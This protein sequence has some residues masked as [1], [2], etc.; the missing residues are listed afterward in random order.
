MKYVRIIE[1][2]NYRSSNYGRL[3]CI[4]IYSRRTVTKI[5]YHSLVTAFSNQS[6]AELFSV[7]LIDQ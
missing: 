2:S 7:T 6:N 3:H 1:S 5:I 4:E